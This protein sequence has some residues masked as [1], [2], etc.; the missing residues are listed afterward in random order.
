[1]SLVKKASLWLIIVLTSM[2]LIGCIVTLEENS[3]WKLESWKEFKEEIREEY[4]FINNIEIYE[5]TT[6]LCFNFDIN[7]KFSLDEIKIVFKKTRRFL[8][9]K[10]IFSELRKYHREKNKGTLAQL[11]IG[12][13]EQNNEENYYLFSSVSE[14]GK[15]TKYDSFKK[16]YI[17][18]D[19]IYTEYN[20]DKK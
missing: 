2:T 12:F 14:D 15:V 5:N 1:M 18:N 13:K 7:R 9:D 20:P 8:L 17:E 6:T 11:Y 3:E 10:E 19:D 4:N 16:W